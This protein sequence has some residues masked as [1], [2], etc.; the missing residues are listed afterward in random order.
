M[1]APGAP[2]AVCRYARYPVAPATSGQSSVTLDVEPV[3]VAMTSF[4]PV[5]SP[6]ALNA[7]TR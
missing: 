1:R 6:S 7:V 2:A 4:E 3:T 5:V